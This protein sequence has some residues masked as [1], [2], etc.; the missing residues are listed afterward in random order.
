MRTELQEIADSCA[1]ITPSFPTTHTD[2]PSQ[3]MIFLKLAGYEIFFEASLWKE[4]RKIPNT[5]EKKLLSRIEAR[6]ND[7]RPTAC[8]E[9][10]DFDL[11]RIRQRI[12]R[13]VYSIQ[14]NELTVWFIKV[15]HRKGEN[16]IQGSLILIRYPSIVTK[17]EERK[18]PSLRINTASHC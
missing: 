5:D 14:D 13:I 2:M 15:G 11:Y 3:P 1:N 16:L 17:R 9:L 12:Y 4:F 10:T 18:N 6:G 8:E 7:P